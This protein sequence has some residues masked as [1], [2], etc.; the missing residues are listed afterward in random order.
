VAVEETYSGN[1][2]VV[3]DPL[4]GSSNIDAGI[5]VGGGGAGRPS[6]P[7]PTQSSAPGPRAAAA[8]PPGLGPPP[9]LRPPPPRAPPLAHHTHTAARR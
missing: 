9:A 2:I 7:A 8:P 4:D 1:Y 5:S 6:C 3:F